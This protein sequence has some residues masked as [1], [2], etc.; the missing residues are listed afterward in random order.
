[1]VRSFIFLACFMVF[2]HAMA[3]S[4][5]IKLKKNQAL[6]FND[7]VLIP[8]VDTLVILPENISYTIKKDSHQKSDAFY[9]S[10]RLKANSNLFTRILYDLAIRR[11]TPLANETTRTAKSESY[12][13]QFRNKI[14]HN[15]VICHVRVYDG[16][17]S[18]TA[19]VETTTLG[20]FLNSISPKTNSRLI[21][22][23]LL[24]K[25]GDRINPFIIADCERIIRS[26]TFIE[27]ARIYIRTLGDDNQ[28]S[29]T[30][31]V[32][33]RFPYIVMGKYNS[34]E[35]YSIGLGN[36]NIIGT[37]NFL[38]AEYLF[39]NNSSPRKGYDLFFRSQSIHKTFIYSEITLARNWKQKK[40]EMAIKKDFISPE[41][42]YG[43]EFRIGDL[44]NPVQY[45][46]ADSIIND[47]SVRKQFIDT[48]VGRAIQ[49]KNQRS[50][51]TPAIRFYYT[52]YI[53][54]PPVDENE[55]I[56]YHNRHLY[57]GSLSYQR[58]NYLKSYYILSFGISEDIPIGYSISFIHGLDHNEFKLNNYS[59]LNLGGS[60][61]SEKLGYFVMTHEAGSFWNRE[62]I[63]NAIYNGLFG[64]FTPLINLS[65][66]KVRNFVR[67]RFS[68]SFR[69]DPAESFLIN[70][71][72]PDLDNVNLSANRLYSGY[73]ESVWFMPWYFY[74]FRFA[75][76]LSYESGKIKEDRFDIK[77]HIYNGLGAGIRIK[78]ESLVFD[79]FSLQVVWNINPVGHQGPLDFNLKFSRSLLFLNEVFTKKPEV[80]I[81]DR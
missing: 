22:N 30:V 41:I 43:G 17:F 49:L 69:L 44:E 62:N 18:D 51:I 36:R 63:E 1:M 7:S 20:D 58:I 24:I 81:I 71:H 79:T 60:A 26:L 16:S 67:F 15:I 23:Q 6:I 13:E 80:L 57:L 46:I 38:R 37:G 68:D 2:Y 39:N 21:R 70:E 66:I 42:K 75:P 33:D 27:D 61:Y 64:Y 78:N 31:L 52:D 50:V 53:K 48:W 55:L 28:V 3:Q 34:P 40:Y 73:L 19:T 47:I 72:L 76:F 56:R 12:F 4:D 35:N 8:S 77:T 65:R 74:G 59:G 14:I 9:D 54:R 32:K 11:E 45:M 25:E 29:V 5:T 10:L